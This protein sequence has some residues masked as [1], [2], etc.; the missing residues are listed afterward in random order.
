MKRC[1]VLLSRPSNRLVWISLWLRH[2]LSA[3]ICSPHAILH[4]P[5]AHLPTAWL[6]KTQRQPSQAA[7]LC[8]LFERLTAPS[9]RILT[10]WP[11]VNF[12]LW[13]VHHRSTCTIRS[14]KPMLMRVTPQAIRIRARQMVEIVSMLGD[15]IELILHTSLPPF[16]HL[17]KRSQSNSHLSKWWALLS[18]EDWNRL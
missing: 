18:K 5:K 14:I 17:K 10:R 8:H 1:K 7:Q 12:R 16:K 3:P 2:K 4:H 11:K 6:I 15:A 9:S 13:Q